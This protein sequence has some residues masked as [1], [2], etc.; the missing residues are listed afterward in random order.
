MDARNKVI[1]WALS[2]FALALLPAK[3]WAVIGL[4]LA[5]GVFVAGVYAVAL[6]ARGFV[7]ALR[8]EYGD[9]RRHLD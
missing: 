4:A 3:A 5:A 7:R 8:G 2:G 9:I 6:V 1:A